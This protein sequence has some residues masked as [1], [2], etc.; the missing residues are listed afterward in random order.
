M[1]RGVEHAVDVAEQM[2][3]TTDPRDNAL[4]GAARPAR[5]YGDIAI[6]G[7]V[8]GRH[9]LKEGGR[10]VKIEL[11]RGRT[12]SKTLSARARTIRYNAVMYWLVNS[13]TTEDPWREEILLRYRAWNTEN[14][15]VQMFPFRPARMA[16]DDILIHRAVGSPD[17][18]LIA[19]GQVTELAHP[20]SSERWPWQ[21][22]RR[23]LHVCDTLA[24]APS[25]ESAGI[26]AKGL[27]VMKQLSVQEGRLA[28]SLIVAAGRPFTQT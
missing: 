20:S 22:G 19:V 13:G 12:H 25:A 4:R 6:G 16:V 24:G 21:I 28:E 17:C 1:S 8:T 26:A 15:D 9:R 7:P 11:C 2:A 5:G 18:E 27:R 23:L 3:L 14:G 10:R